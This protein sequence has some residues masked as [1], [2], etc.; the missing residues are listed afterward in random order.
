MIAPD[1][2]RRLDLR[3][4]EIVSAERMAGSARL[5]RVDVDL[6]TERRVVVAGLARHYAPESLQG[7]KVILLANLEPA[8]IHG[9][10][11]QGMLLGAA[12]AGAAPALLTVNHPISNGTVVQ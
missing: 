5:L 9:V 12:C 8:L 6:G 1:D 2:F 10:Q 7:L 11:S 3:V 4:G